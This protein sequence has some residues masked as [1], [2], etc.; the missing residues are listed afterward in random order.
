M[1]L[2]AIVAIAATAAFFA[3]QEYNN[4]HLWHAASAMLRQIGHSFGWR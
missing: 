3:D 4:G 2:L 1:R